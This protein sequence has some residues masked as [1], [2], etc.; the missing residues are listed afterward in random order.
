MPIHSPTTPFGRRSL[1][2]D[3]I[4]AGRA[5]RRG[6]V[7][8]SRRDAAQSNTVNK[9]ELFRAVTAAKPVLGLSDRALALLHALLSFHP[10]TAMSLPAVS[11]GADTIEEKDPEAVD[12]SCDLVVFPSNKALAQRAHGMSETTIRRH[13]AALVDAGLIQRRDSPNG[14]RYARKARVEGAG[15][16][17][18]IE[19]RFADAFGFDLTPLVIRASEFQAIAEDLARRA[20]IRAVLRERISLM[21]RDVTTLIALGLETSTPGPFELLHQRALM[22]MMPLRRVGDDDARLGEF[23]DALAAL[24]DETLA[25]LDKTLDANADFQKTDGNA[26]DNGWHHSNSNTQP[27]SDSELSIKQTE[28]AIDGEDVVN[29]ASITARTLETGT[30]RTASAERDVPLGLILEACPDIKDYGPSGA[31]QNWSDF[32]AAVNLVRPMIGISPDAWAD[33]QDALG[34]AGACTA[35]ALILQRSIHSSEAGPAMAKDADPAGSAPT[36]RLSVNGSPAI[37]SPGGY[38]RA[39]SEKAKDGSFSLGPVLMATIGQRLK[40]RQGR[41]GEVANGGSSAS[42][43]ALKP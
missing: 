19:G 15:G 32:R 24:K 43:K 2:F 9:W 31:I 42:N 8:G 16:R 22:L 18:S 23:C 7:D 37:R 4:A 10:E 29:R 21:R 3:Q 20:R 1:S 40:A 26:N 30:A 39:L 35:V 33:A 41:G 13:L 12:P 36:A 14:K 17:D 5:V 34:T 28:P 11:A 6:G 27:Q 38:L 25:A